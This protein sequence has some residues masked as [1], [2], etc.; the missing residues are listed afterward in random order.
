MSKSTVLA[1]LKAATQGLVRRAIGVNAAM[2][3]RGDDIVDAPGNTLSRP[4]AQ[5]AWVMRAIKKVAQPISA[6]DLCFYQGDQELEDPR[7]DEFWNEPV[8]G[9]SRSDFIEAAVGWLKLEGELFLL[10]DDVFLLTARERSVFPKLIMAR[11]DRMR[12]ILEGGLVTAWAFTDDA[13]RIHLLTPEHVVHIKYWNPYDPIRGLAEYD[14]ARIATESDHAA[15]TFSRNL[16]RN[17]GDT[18]PIISAKSGMIDDVQQQ[19]ILAQ[20]RMKRAMAQRGVY[21]TAFLTSDVTVQNPSADAV[22]TDFAAQRL[23]NRHE[24]FIAFGVPPSMADVAA[25]YSIGSASDWHMLITETCIPTG[26]KLAQAISRVAT[27]M[28]GRPTR[29]ELEWDEHPVMQTVRRERIA[30][31]D[32]LWNK[33]MPLSAVSEYLKLDIEPFPGWDIGY[34]PF[35]VSPANALPPEP[36]TAPALAE[37]IEDMKSALRLA[38]V[39]R[40][41]RGLA[42]GCGDHAEPLTR[43]EQTEVEEFQT[44]RP[45]RELSQWRALMAARKGVIKAYESKFNRT[46]MTARAQVLRRIENAKMLRALEQRAGAAADFLF[47]LASFKVDFTAA[48]RAVGR[49]ALTSAGQQLFAEVKKEDPFTMPDPKAVEFLQG[50]ENNLLGISDDIFGQIKNTLE[51]GIQGGDTLK[52]LSE[53]VRTEFNAISAKRAT[54]IAMTE[55]SAAYAE[56][57]SEAMRQAGVQFKRWLTSGNANVRASH[58]AVNGVTIP[59]NESFTVVNP[60]TGEFDE[61]PHPGASGGAP[62]NVINCHCV[63]IAVAAPANPDPNV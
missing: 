40:S 2:F 15:G 17:N 47:D 4:F 21:Q 54:T 51:E 18:G 39:A 44:A 5:S 52:E 9:M 34:L 22:N 46:L 60:K 8:R 27:L 50:R 36:D 1:S 12:A 30:S 57:R 28:T 49:N 58:Q 61:V 32:V 38:P 55:T 56:A 53:R 62:W 45:A 41:A 7:L 23:G 25:S 37:P 59:V 26:E 63:S 19:Q 43:A 48:M 13:H 35:S 20:L 11:P 42:C 6:V 3:I 14:A 29:A 16:M 24:I 31:V 10:V 33:G